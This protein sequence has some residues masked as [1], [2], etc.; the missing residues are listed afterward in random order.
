[1]ENIKNK[2]ITTYYFSEKY[3]DYHFS[4]KEEHEDYIILSVLY[5]IKNDDYLTKFKDIFSKFECEIDK[6]FYNPR[7]LIKLSTE[8]FLKFKLSSSSYQKEE[9]F[10]TI[11]LEYDN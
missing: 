1:M 7:L 2:Q 4:L 3:K 8:D 9:I 6:T 10:F 5:K 11:I